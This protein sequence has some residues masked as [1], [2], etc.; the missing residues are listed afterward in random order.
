MK[1]I[2][3]FGQGLGNMIEAI[4]TYLYLRK[5]GHDCDVFYI[6]RTGVDGD[7]SKIFF[8]KKLVSIY[9]GVCHTNGD[10]PLEECRFG[11]KY[12][13]QFVSCWTRPLPDIPVSASRFPV[14]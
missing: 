11:D 4:P 7:I 5:L 12:D 10:L 13:G 6:Y 14:N 9:G 2:V 8:L 3:T 1:Y